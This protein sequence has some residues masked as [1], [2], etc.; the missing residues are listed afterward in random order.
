MPQEYTIV[1]QSP[2]L[3]TSKNIFESGIQ[4]T[5]NPAITC[6]VPGD[7]SV[8]YGGQIGEYTLFGNLLFLN[9]WLFFTPTFTTASGVIYITGRPH[10]E[11]I[12]SAQVGSC[13]LSNF[14]FPAGWTAPQLTITTALDRMEVTLTKSGAASTSLQMDTACVSASSYALF[15]Q[16]AHLVKD[17]S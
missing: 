14:T 3:R 4:G 12:N 5:W 15:G 13:S 7:L 1:Q 10:H 17:K 11:V 16:I 2:R 6:A 8:S 9:F